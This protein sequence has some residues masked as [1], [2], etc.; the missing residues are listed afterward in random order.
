MINTDVLKS[1]CVSP[2]HQQTPYKL[3]I[4]PHT[5]IS[6]CIRQFSKNIL[7]H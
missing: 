1:V 2:L 3:L 4:V 7:V 5:L 6:E